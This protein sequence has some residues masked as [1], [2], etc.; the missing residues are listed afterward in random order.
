[1]PYH[2]TDAEPPFNLDSLRPSSVTQGEA[3][4]A[5]AAAIPSS[6]PP[7]SPPPAPVPAP[8]PPP[9]IDTFARLQLAAALLEY[10]HDLDGKLA[11][12]SAIFTPYRDAAAGAGGTGIGSGSTGYLICQDQEEQ[13]YP[14]TAGGGDGAT[15]APSLSIGLIPPTSL[16]SGNVVRLENGQERDGPAPGESAG[17][18]DNDNDLASEWGLDS[19][20]TK[21]DAKNFDP[22]VLTSGTKLPANKRK[23]RRQRRRSL[24]HS[25]FDDYAFG[26]GGGP[27]DTRSQGDPVTTS[28]FELNHRRSESGGL[29]NT[30]SL[31]DVLDHTQLRGFDERPRGTKAPRKTRISLDLESELDQAFGGSFDGDAE[32]GARS[33]SSAYGG[34][35]APTVRTGKISFD[36]E[37]LAGPST[38]SASYAQ[39]IAARPSSS[40]GLLNTDTTDETSPSSSYVSRFD[41][42]ALARARAEEEAT[43]IRFPNSLHPKI[44]VMPAP[45]ADLVVEEQRQKEEAEQIAQQE[46]EEQAKPRVEREAGKLYGKSLMDELNERKKRQK[47]KQMVFTGDNR[48]AMMENP[49]S[50]AHR[51][52]QLRRKSSPLRGESSALNG[53]TE[54]SEE[55]DIRP[56]M[57]KPVEPVKIAIDDADPWAKYASHRSLDALAAARDSTT[58]D[59]QRMSS[60]L[61]SPGIDDPSQ[62]SPNRA[63]TA[64]LLSPPDAVRLTSSMSTRELQDHYRRQSTMTLQALTAGKGSE[65]QEE[66][67]EEDDD[68]PLDTR[69]AQLAQSPTAKPASATQPSKD[70]QGIPTSVFGQDLIMA[71]ELEKL[72]KI[73]RIEEAEKRIEAEKA[74]VK[75]AELD[76][77]EAKKRAKAEK[78]AKKREEKEKEKTRSK[79]VS[80]FAPFGEQQLPSPASCD[81]PQLGRL[82]SSHPDTQSRRSEWRVQSAAADGVVF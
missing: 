52:E 42:K 57:P 6:P 58:P 65:R 67:S 22:S 12:Q 20:M 64:A 31:P 25:E 75:Q 55:D 7:Q 79:S 44:L 82:A 61:P 34:G 24:A 17:H 35:L 29:Q 49:V 33:R 59:P 5:A 18:D 21:F 19:V 8:A 40:L 54:D 70:A 77:K 47:S 66:D 38:T 80:S 26:G 71:R 1:M 28:S 81:G 43:R 37:E 56:L 10:D 27:Y 39:E 11:E 46:A 45:L 16:L 32:D 62:Q 15:V 63:S 13:P 74:R 36:V 73:L 4:A 23:K 60:L 53:D 3:L 2:H 9:H 30:R 51:Q 48:R 68:I 50:L 76:A 72:E 78:K 69:R 41:P 14:T